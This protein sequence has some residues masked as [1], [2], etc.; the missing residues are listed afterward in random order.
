[1]RVPN[2]RPPNQGD[3]PDVDEQNIAALKVVGDQLEIVTHALQSNIS[4]EDNANA[5][6][7]NLSLKSGEPL[8][9]ETKNIKGKAIEVVVLDQEK[10]DS[11]K[12]AWEVVNENEIRVQVTW[13]N[14]DNQDTFISTRLLVRGGS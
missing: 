3:F 9:I 10:F 11:T 1:M 5:E 4:P 12:L 2:F 13:D 6:V 8:N 7:K 14:E